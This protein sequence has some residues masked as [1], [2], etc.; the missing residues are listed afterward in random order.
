[1]RPRSREA[2]AKSFCSSMCRASISARNAIAR[3]PGTDPLR[4][5]I[6]SVR[7]MPRSTDIPKGVEEL[8]HHLG[9]LVFLEGGLRISVDPM[10]PLSHL[11]VKIGNS[12]D[13][14]HEIR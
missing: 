12:I 10:P 11:G 6:T 9:S 4:V 5:P 1:M 13:N 2:C 3:L 7:A 8:R 14:R